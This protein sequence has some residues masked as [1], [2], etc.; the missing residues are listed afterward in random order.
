MLTL[1]CAVATAAVAALS[2]VNFFTHHYATDLR[3]PLILATLALYARTRVYYTPRALR[4]R[5]PLWLGFGLVA[6]FIWLAE[7]IGTFGGAWVYPDQADGWKI[8]GLSKLGAWYLLMILSFVMVTW[9]QPPRR[10]HARP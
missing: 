2:Y 4:L 8:V 1:I 5:M 10:E 7:N 6:L 9:V 3:V